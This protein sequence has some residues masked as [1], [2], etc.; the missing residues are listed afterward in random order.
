MDS[1]KISIGQA[2]SRMDK[3]H[4]EDNEY[5]LKLEIS[6]GIWMKGCDKPMDKDQKL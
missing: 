4:E 6:Q 2:R 1:H 5:G 3:G